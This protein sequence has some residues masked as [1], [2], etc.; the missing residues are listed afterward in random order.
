MLLPFD[1]HHVGGVLRFL[2][3]S[4]SQVCL[5]WGDGGDASQVTNQGDEAVHGD[6]V[7][8]LHQS[9][10]GGIHLGHVDGGYPM[11]L[12]KAGHGQDAVHVAHR[13]VEAQF[14]HEH[15]R[16]HVTRDLSRGYQ[17]ADG[18]GE[19]VRRAFLSE[20]SGGQVND[21]TGS[22]VGQARVDDRRAHSLP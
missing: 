19:I 12:S 5:V 17:Q 11:G 3:L 22:S 2:I 10:F 13:A 4:E 15:R 8:T 16:F 7:Q 6:D 21:G 14:A 9:R 20:V 18:N 1:V